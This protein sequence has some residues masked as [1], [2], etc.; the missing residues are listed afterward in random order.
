[1][2]TGF[3]TIILI[4]AFAAI[5]I[6]TYLKQQSDNYDKLNQAEQLRIT[7]GKVAFDEKNDDTMEINRIVTGAGVYFNMLV[8]KTGN[9]IMIDS[10]LKLSKKQY[11]KA[12]KYAWENRKGGVVK[13]NGREWQY[14]VAPAIT[15]FD[16]QN[17][18]KKNNQKDET[19]LMRF[20]DI[21]DTKKSLSTLALT[22]VI[23][24][25]GL[26]IFFFLVIVY[27]TNRAISPMEEAWRKQKQFIADASHELKTP[28]SIISTNVGVLYSSKE[29]TIL[30][31][32][33]WLDN[34]SRGTERMNGLVNKL[35][36]I[37]KTDTLFEQLNFTK[38]SVDQLLK[39][40]LS[41]YEN[42]FE[43]KNI[44]VNQNLAKLTA[45][46]DEILLQQLFDIFIDNAG[47]YT[48]KNGSFDVSL[49]SKGRET[50]ITFKNTGAGISQE[51][52]P[53]IFDRFYR[54]ND[55]RQKY[56]GS[57]GLGLSIAQSI[58]EQLGGKIEAKSTVDEVTEFVIHLHL[59][60]EYGR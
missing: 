2:T 59:K 4:T 8:D 16:Y 48:N 6:T 39:D 26:M 25:I 23:V 57:Y 5:F 38:V 14:V 55:V 22:L 35:L 40:S 29:D 45:K 37:A 54:T 49:E 53:K 42:I 51:D 52:L 41:N 60:N 7:G 44:T 24:G 36:T 1:M 18:S 33:N 58:T 30:D 13:M 47:K 3:V 19:Y 56:E 46:T 10:A 27:F 21:T 12:A 32:L 15:D 50:T 31:Q 20:L 17:S 28:L 11:N 43:V 34:I 9:P